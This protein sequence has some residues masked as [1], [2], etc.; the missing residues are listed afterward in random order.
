MLFGM[1]RDVYVVDLNKLNELLP[2]FNV[3][4]NYH[5]IITILI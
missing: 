3:P 4:N 2:N 1:D 5:T